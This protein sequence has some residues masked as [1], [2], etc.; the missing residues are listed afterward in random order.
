[1]QKKHI[2][3]YKNQNIQILIKKNKLSRNYKLTFDRKNL[4]GL[5]S[6]PFYVTFKS[7]LEF[8]HENIEWLY[9]EYKK[10]LP[11][12]FL[13]HNCSLLF[14][15]KKTKVI[16]EK[17]KISRV[18]FKENEIIVQ[19]NNNNHKKLLNNWINEQILSQS[20]Y[21]IDIISHKL[22]Q[23]IK[24][25]KLS[26]SFNYWGSCNSSRTIHINWRLIFAPAKVLEYIIIH[27]LCHLI[28][29]NHTQNFWELVKKLCPDYKKQIIWL[30]KN[31]NYLYRIRFN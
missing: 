17:N 6:I 13:K 31:D 12:I 2:I 3:F 29:F 9:D 18:L 10:F 16:F 4:Y 7:G 22:K 14:R 28:E 26:N 21:Y 19:S 15:G 25:V 1:M 24:T 27:E 30:K 5:V 11:I 23:D 8:A 20:K